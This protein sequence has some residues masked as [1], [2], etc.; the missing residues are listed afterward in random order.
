MNKKKEMDIL[1]AAAKNYRRQTVEGVQ[2]I[3]WDLLQLPAG[4][5]READKRREARKKQ[6][7]AFA[8]ENEDVFM[9]DTCQGN[10]REG[11]KDREFCDIIFI[12]SRIDIWEK[13]ICENFKDYEIGKRP[14]KGNGRKIGHSLILS[15]HDEILVTISMWPSKKKVMIQPGKNDEENLLEWIRCSKPFFQMEKYSANDNQEPQLTANVEQQSQENEN[16]KENGGKGKDSEQETLIINE[17]LCFVQCKIDVTPK[18]I[19]SRV[20]TSF[21]DHQ[22]IADAKQLLYDVVIPD[23]RK[24]VKIGNNKSQSEFDDIYKLL[25]SGKGNQVK[26]V[27]RNL[28][29][30][31]S[32]SLT[33]YNF[34]NVVNDMERMKADIA[35]LKEMQQQLTEQRTSVGASVMVGLNSGAN[36]ATSQE[37]N[38]EVK[39][40]QEADEMSDKNDMSFETLSETVCSWASDPDDSVE[41]KRSVTSTRLT[42]VGNS[43]VEDKDDGYIMAKSKRK[44]QDTAVTH[45]PLPVKSDQKH[46]LVVGS[47]VGSSSIKAVPPRQPRPKMPWYNRKITGVFATRF[48]PRTSS[49]QI[50]SH[51]KQHTGL[52]IWV[53]KLET[54]YADY[55]SFYLRAYERNV[56]EALL[57][58]DI[59]PEGILLKPYME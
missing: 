18:D 58:A 30:L 36:A 45:E 41:D 17:L 19:L 14:I 10:K 11:G 4:N 5:K 54:K 53:Q 55:C 12:T 8:A 31:P 35:G 50:E 28:S 26:F 40:M 37:V 56:Q 21:Y 1:T 52:D 29:N 27:A 51:I 47:G 46:L 43:E 15:L 42:D 34:G 7:D 38:K 16:K 2:C 25:L 49:K 44:E 39:Y 9:I 32:L 6:K 48:R 22:T 3:V 59:W 13:W 33:D 20:C 57:C 24:S 23:Q